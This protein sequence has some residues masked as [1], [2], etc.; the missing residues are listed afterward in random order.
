MCFLPV[1][2]GRLHFFLLGAHVKQST[3]NAL[4]LLGKVC[5]YVAVL[6]SPISLGGSLCKSS[7]EASLHWSALQF[8][9]LPD[10]A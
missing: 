6:F 7:L 4:Y 5:V 2:D 1:E 10:E 8:I 9:G 3:P